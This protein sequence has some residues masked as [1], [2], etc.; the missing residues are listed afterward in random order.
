MGEHLGGAAEGVV[1]VQGVSR[2]KD[3][4]FDAEE[5][6]YTKD[7]IA[8]QC[9]TVVLHWLIGIGLFDIFLINDY[10]MAPK[11]IVLYAVGRLCCMTP[12]SLLALAVAVR[13][14]RTYEYAVCVPPIAM[15]AVLSF[16]IV[17][18]YGSYRGW[19]L[20]GDILLMMC[21]S[22]ISRAR[23]RFA[24]FTL[25]IQCLCF[26]YVLFRSDAI[27]SESVLVGSMFCLSGAVF[28]LLTTYSLDK[29]SRAAFSMRT[30][31]SLLVCELETA[32]TVDTLTGL[33]NRRGLARAT[34]ALWTVE[35]DCDF[36]VSLILIDVD[37]FK[38]FND[39]YG[40][41]AGDQCL[42]TIAEQIKN[43]LRHEDAFAARFG[44]EE[45]LV[46]LP[47]I[48]LAEAQRV[49]ERLRLAIMDAAVPH[50][51]AAPGAVVTASM[52]VAT[53]TTRQCTWLELTA[54][55]DTALYKAKSAG[56][57]CIWPPQGEYVAHRALAR[58]AT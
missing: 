45:L 36:S 18:T 48:S 13:F 38:S 53:A 30:Q 6:A 1:A 57:N 17:S 27:P 15:S 7:L 42:A 25:S 43:T 16:L 54:Q 28:A 11:D 49:A 8:G 39:N 2:S 56:R 40:H 5:D 46:M 52:G 34:D 44:G 33:A 19:Y 14:R 4:L 31:I 3:G 55:A 41:M 24:L 32:A 51:V 47:G 22:V 23:F 20:F 9:R 35:K 26:V 29:A 58:C 12:V 37:K 50:P 21:G 10:L